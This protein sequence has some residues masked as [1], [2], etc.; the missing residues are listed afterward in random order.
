M[1]KGVSEEPNHTTAAKSLV[2]YKSFNI[3]YCTRTNK[4][5]ETPQKLV[6]LC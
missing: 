1:G 6:A 2:L 5:G 3:L 4:E